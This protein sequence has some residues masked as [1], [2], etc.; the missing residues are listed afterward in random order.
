MSQV[1]KEF[2]TRKG[3]VA[4]PKLDLIYANRAIKPTCSSFFASSGIIDCI[5][6]GVVSAE[7]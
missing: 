4:S 3:R 6:D 7:K 1:A 5:D 2:G